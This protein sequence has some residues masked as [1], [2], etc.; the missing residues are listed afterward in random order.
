LLSCT[1]S[2][3]SKSPDY[4]LF[5]HSIVHADKRR[6]IVADGTRGPLQ[7]KVAVISSMLFTSYVAFR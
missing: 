5:S 1:F 6:G 2:S 7:P 4:S 3:L